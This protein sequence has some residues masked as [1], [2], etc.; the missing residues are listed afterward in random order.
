MGEKKK[1]WDLTATSSMSAAAEWL[2]KRGDAIVVLVIR[3]QDVA[4]SVDPL[5][6]PRDAAELVKQE[7]P[8]LRDQ[9]LLQRL[10]RGKGKS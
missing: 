1:A 5:C 8:Q 10:K 7:L 3:A 6:S 9:L 2:R 4:F